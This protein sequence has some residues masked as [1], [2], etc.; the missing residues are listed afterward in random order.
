MIG[1]LAHP[2]NHGYEFVR[3]PQCVKVNDIELRNVRQLKEEAEKV[4]RSA[5]APA[6]NA[7]R[8]VRDGYVTFSL[9]GGRSFVIDAKKAREA[10][11]PALP[12]VSDA[13]RRQR[14]RYWP[15]TR[16]RRHA[17]P[18]CSPHPR[19]CLRAPPLPST[20]RDPATR[21]TTKKATRWRV[22]RCG[23]L[24]EAMR[25]EPGA[26]GGSRTMRCERHN[27]DEPRCVRL[28]AD[29]WPDTPGA[30]FVS[31]PIGVAG[32]QATSKRVCAAAL[33]ASPF[34]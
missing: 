5:Y 33:D 31:L 16:C 12:S 7:A 21:R 26:P 28:A 27:F 3:Y 6:L 1:V 24:L 2:I 11:R 19:S 4:A 29:A 32:K 25:H 14:Q 30:D 22:L 34:P 20:A 10:R 8:Q 15:R 9:V 18:T 23:A 17:R 13:P